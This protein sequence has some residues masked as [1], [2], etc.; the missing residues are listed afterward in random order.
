MLIKNFT[1][2]MKPNFFIRLKCMKI[3]VVLL[4]FVCLQVL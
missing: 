3:K 4:T 2:Q 1:E